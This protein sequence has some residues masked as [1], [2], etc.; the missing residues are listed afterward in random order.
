MIFNTEATARTS[1]CLRLINTRE[2]QVKTVYSIAI[3]PSESLN[4]KTDKTKCGKN[5]G[6]LKLS[7]SAAGDLKW[8]SYFRKLISSKKFNIH[9]LCGPVIP[10]LGLYPREWQIFCDSYFD[11]PNICWILTMYQVGCVLGFFTETEPITWIERDL[12]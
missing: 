5:T 4:L 1:G 8:H 12:L 2:I 9:L 3:H 7:C 6:K 11:S 10:L